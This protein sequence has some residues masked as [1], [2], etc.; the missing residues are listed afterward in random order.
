M[1]S[2]DATVSDQSR[3]IGVELLRGVA[4]CLTFVMHFAW[5]EAATFLAVDIEQVSIC[6][7]RSV[8]AIALCVGYGS[9][10]GVYIF[11]MISGF[12]IGRQWLTRSSY[13]PLRFFT[14]RARRIFP[15]FWAALIGAL[16]LAIYR[17][18][19]VPTSASDWA[20][21]AS[22]INWFS[23]ATSPPWLIVSW[24]LQ[25][26]WLFY[27]SMPLLASALKR[28]PDKYR[29]LALWS[30]TLILVLALKAIGERHFAYPVYFSI[31][32]TLSLMPE[33]QATSIARQTPLALMI[34]LI[35]A[36]Q[37]A[38]TFLEPVGAAKPAWKLTWFDAF[39]AAFAIFGGLAFVKCA[40]EPPKWML[41]NWLQWLGKYSY[42]FYLWHL[43]VLILVF[44]GANNS[45]MHGWL[46]NANWAFRWFLLIGSALAITIVVSALSY[47][48]F[49]APYFSSRNRER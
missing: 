26:E 32:I 14:A 41:T 44:H 38:Y 4:V 13:S 21:N 6:H 17:N 33:K 30:I 10:Y 5:L 49:E 7:S 35:L 22:L 25:V 1:T 9:L 8:E 48:I 18:V 36:L 12:L 23:P 43:S 39:A 40:L 27:L 31:G 28:T 3:F 29:V 47:R 20:A 15:A 11:F 46:Q 42:S 37:V 19:P 45:L 34:T 16:C 2:S 24:S